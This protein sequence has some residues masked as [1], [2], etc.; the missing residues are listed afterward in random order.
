M[1]FNSVVFGALLSRKEDTK[2]LDNSSSH[3]SM[4]M[5]EQKTWLWLI[6]TINYSILVCSMSWSPVWNL[7]MATLEQSDSICRGFIRPL[8]P[9]GLVKQEVKPRPLCNQPCWAHYHIPYFNT[10]GRRTTAHTCWLLIVL[11]FLFFIL[12][13]WAIISCFQKLGVAATFVWTEHVWEAECFPPSNS[14]NAFPFSGCN[15]GVS[16]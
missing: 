9:F 16:A 11:W 13:V 8:G 5:T 7:G 3:I 6:Q 10:N 1:P 2:F 4:K 15:S 12:F 14:L